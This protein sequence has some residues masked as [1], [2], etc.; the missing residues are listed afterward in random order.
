MNTETIKKLAA[1]WADATC[2]EPQMRRDFVREIGK[3]IER[4]IDTSL[5][6]GWKL[7]K[8]RKPYMV[9]VFA[10]HFFVFALTNRQA[11]D[12]GVHSDGMLA[13][14]LP[15]SIPTP[16]VSEYP[17]VINELE[18]DN[19]R[20][21]NGS[22]LITGHLQY[23]RMRPLTE[24][25]GLV[26]ELNVKDRAMKRLYMYPP[27]PMLND[28]GVVKL[29]FPAV[30]DEKDEATRAWHGTTGAFCRFVTVCDPRT[31]LESQ[32]LSS[33]YGVLLDVLPAQRRGDH[34]PG[35][36]GTH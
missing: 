30:R 22:D 19:C 1:A 7:T 33:P 24:R 25:V 27:H 18:L 36:R 5:V 10:K 20:C 21:L 8:S 28:S 9:Y 35:S 26:L 16:A 29:G 31:G 3:A 2:P 17:F 23:E 6:V 11:K 32:P 4:N 13:T 34:F 15:L 14:R 12:L